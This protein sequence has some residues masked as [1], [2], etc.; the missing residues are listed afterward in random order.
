MKSLEGLSMAPVI[1]LSARDAAHN[2]KRALDG[3]ATSWQ[4]SLDPVPEPPGWRLPSRISSSVHI[5]DTAAK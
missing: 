2:K 1:V 3:G 4:S 5:A